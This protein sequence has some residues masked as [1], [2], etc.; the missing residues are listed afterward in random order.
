MKLKGAHMKP[1]YKVDKRNFDSKGFNLKTYL[2][3]KLE[4]IINEKIEEAFSKKR[5]KQG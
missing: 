1:K 2:D 4:K 5:N 3:Q